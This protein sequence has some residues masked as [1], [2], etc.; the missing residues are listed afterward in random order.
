MF[1][2]VKL[3]IILFFNTFR[4]KLLQTMNVKV[5][6]FDFEFEKFEIFVRIR[7]LFVR[8]G[9]MRRN[10]ETNSFQEL[11][12]STPSTTTILLPSGRSTTGTIA[13]SGAVQ[14]GATIG[15]AGNGGAGGG[16]GIEERKPLPITVFCGATICSLIELITYLQCG[17]PV[18]VVQ[19][20][21]WSVI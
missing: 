10:E 7:K 8:Q 17:V 20:V 5:F 14:R 6:K 12:F 1:F 11:L 16:G 19:V 3:S 15:S 4:L 2:R 13:G 9:K 18:L 21:A